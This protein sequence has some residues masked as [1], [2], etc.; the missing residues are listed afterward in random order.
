MTTIARL[1]VG[2][3]LTFWVNYQPGIYYYNFDG[4]YS[5]IDSSLL[6]NVPI[7]DTPV[8]DI[9]SVFSDSEPLTQVFNTDD[10]VNG[11]SFYYDSA[12]NALYIRLANYDP[13]SAHLINAGPVYGLANEYYVDA[14][15]GTTYASRL[16]STVGIER[17]KDPLF[18]GKITYSDF[19]ITVDN[20][21]GELYDLQNWDVYGQPLS[22]AIGENTQSAAS[23]TTVRT[24]TVKEYIFKG[25]TVE[26][27]VQDSR[28]VL[29][30]DL[31]VKTV[32]TTD[33]ANADR[34]IGKLIPLVYGECRGVPCRVTNDAT[35]TTSFSF[36]AC[37][38]DDHSGGVTSI[39]TVYV[40]GV[41]VAFSGTSLTNATFNLA[42]SVYELGKSVTCDMVGFDDVGS[43]PLDIAKDI[44]TTYLNVDYNSNY[45]DLA[46]WTSATVGKDDIGICLYKKESIAKAMEKIGATFLEGL[47]VTPDNKFTWKQ[48]SDLNAPI[49]QVKA[50]DWLAPPDV[51]FSS[52]EAISSA[53]VGYSQ[54]WNTGDFKTTV[55]DSIYD[56][57]VRK[58][59]KPKDQSFETLY[60][61]KTTADTFAALL[62]ERYSDVQILVYGDISLKLENQGYL[63]NPLALQ[64]GDNVDLEIDGIEIIAGTLRTTDIIGRIKAELLEIEID[65]ETE[66]A[67]IVARYISDYSGE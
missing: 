28:R 36:V 26:I 20:A 4:D 64:P 34:D 56:E 9:A 50:E 23:F 61:D 51:E 55:N 45:F 16:L 5:F 58:F 18:F 3:E 21:D 62:I 37:D 27:I 33:Y 19:S 14:D 57:F 63:F 49:Y 42:S 6:V 11:P 2:T 24:G 43:N 65:P 66:T 8:S 41:S 32:N 40:D 10:L 13:P 53:S 67:R 25:D 38:T 35:A 22:I 47:G 39:D 59:K 48:R 52:D 31:P 17:R 54:F 12:D 46:A 30:R 29:E 44:L 60:P 1:S 7:F 15:T